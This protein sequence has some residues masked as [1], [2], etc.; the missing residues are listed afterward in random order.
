MFVFKT[1]SHIAQARLKLLFFRVSRVYSVGYRREAGE[2]EGGEKRESAKVTSSG[3]KRKKKVDTNFIP[4]FLFPNHDCKVT[5]S[6]WACLQLRHMTSSRDRLYSQ[7]V[8]Q[9]KLFLELLC[10]DRV[11]KVDIV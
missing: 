9:N 1:R 3:E 11:T 4:M 2:G 10:Q 8:Y 7:M 6:S 5:S